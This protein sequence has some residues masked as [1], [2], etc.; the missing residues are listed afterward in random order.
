MRIYL[1]SALR[2]MILRIVDL[3][4]RG[5][6]DGL[7]PDSRPAYGGPL[8]TA[9]RGGQV[10]RQAEKAFGQPPVKLLS[11]WPKNGCCPHYSPYSHYSHYYSIYILPVEKQILLLLDQI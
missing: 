5:G 6:V 11:S 4:K 1:W 8:L 9:C 7:V 10:G 3:R 2:N